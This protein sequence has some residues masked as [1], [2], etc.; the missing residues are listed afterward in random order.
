MMKNA[1]TSFCIDWYNCGLCCGEDIV[2]EKTTLYLRKKSIK[3]SKYNGFDEK[4]E[5]RTYNVLKKDMDSFFEFINRLDS[6][7]EWE[8]D[9]MVQVCDGSRWEMRLRHCDNT[10]KLIEGAVEKPVNAD[11]I[12][13]MIINMLNKSMCFDEPILFGY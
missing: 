1:I 11:K 2:R 8:S 4:V 3:V 5:E 10:I 9:Y 7:N 12:E 6:N 13:K